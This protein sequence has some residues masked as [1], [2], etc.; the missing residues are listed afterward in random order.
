MKAI[1]RSSTMLFEDFA[2]QLVRFRRAATTALKFFS[3]C[4]NVLGQF[5]AAQFGYSTDQYFDEC[6]LLVDGERISRFQ[7]I[8]ERTVSLGPPFRLFLEHAQACDMLSTC[9][10]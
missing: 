3:R 6:L 10:R 5:R 4:G 1:D 2:H 9:R 7:D 8:G